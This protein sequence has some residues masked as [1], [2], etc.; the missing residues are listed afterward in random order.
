MGLK[1]QLL[2]LG[3]LQT[4]FLLGSRLEIEPNEIPL[5]PT[6]NACELHRAELDQAGLSSCCGLAH[7]SRP[8]E[9][10]LPYKTPPRP[11]G[12]ASSSS[13]PTCAAATHSQT[14]TPEE[15]EE[16]PWPWAR[17]RGSPRAGRAARR[18]RKLLACLRAGGVGA[19]P[20][21]LSELLVLA[22]G[23]WG[24]LIWDFFSFSL[25]VWVQRRSLFQEG[26]VRHQGADRVLRP[27]HR[28]D[29]RLQDPGD[30]GSFVRSPFAPVN[31]NPRSDP[32]FH[33][34]SLSVSTC[35][36][37]I[38]LDLRGCVILYLSRLRD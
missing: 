27:Q 14:L 20:L 25:S 1:A 22:W 17:T 18:R 30:Q 16:Q 8:I 24:I 34:V 15:R 33:F 19:T 12:F 9:P 7:P 28:Q 23:F 31:L 13:S 26:L 36:E 29:P 3:L 35:A 32:C 4:R 21:V 37:S 5:L 11:L 38:C 6:C 10:P 2:E